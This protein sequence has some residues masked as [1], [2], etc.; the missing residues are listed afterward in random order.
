[1]DNLFF[2]FVH[3]IPL[4]RN[5]GVYW[6]NWVLFGTCMSSI[7]LLL[8]FRE[9][10]ERTFVDQTTPQAVHGNTQPFTISGIQTVGD[11][12]TESK[13][14][15]V[16]C[17]NLCVTVEYIKLFR[18]DI[19]LALKLD[20][21]MS[22][23]QKLGLL[24]IIHMYYAYFL[25]LLTSKQWD[26]KRPADSTMLWHSIIWLIPVSSVTIVVNLKT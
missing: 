15:I 23:F 21:N 3:Y 20:F 4:F 18:A 26:F 8:I 10:Y 17:I 2:V 5:A 6:M 9:T 19:S 1:M 14:M 24:C 25:M 13:F 12:G 7:A 11:T 16:S 22:H